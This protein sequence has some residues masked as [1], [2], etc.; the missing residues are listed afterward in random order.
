MS[1][2]VGL[3]TVTLL[4]VLLS[5]TGSAIVLL[6]DDTVTDWENGTFA[7]T[8]G[9]SGV[10]Q[11]SHSDTF[12]DG[13]DNNTL[14]TDWKR[15]DEPG[16][17]VWYTDQ[18]RNGE[19]IE[20]EM[21]EGA[22][23]GFRPDESGEGGNPDEIVPVF[24]WV[25][26]DWEEGSANNTLV[27]NITPVDMESDKAKTGIAIM[28]GS[29]DDGI[30]ASFSSASSDTFT[31]ACI[32]DDFESGTD[33]SG[34]TQI[35]HNDGEWLS[36]R[37]DY[38]PSTNEW[39]C[40]RKSQG[41]KTWTYDHHDS[42]TGTHNRSA[43]GHADWSSNG[44]GTTRSRHN[45]ISVTGV[46][47][48]SG[49]YT[50]QR[51]NN[52]DTQDWGKIFVNVTNLPASGDPDLV[53]RTRD[54]STGDILETE[55]FDLSS[56][57]QN[58]ST[59]ISD[60]IDAD[61]V[62]NGS[63]P[64]T[65]VSWSIDQV[66]IYHS[67]KTPPNITIYNPTNTTFSTNVLNLNVTADETTDDWQYS[68]DSN[69]N[70][71][72]S[73]NTT[74]SGLSMGQHHLIVYATDTGDN[75]GKAEVYFT[76]SDDDSWV[77]ATGDEM[78]GTL[79]MLG[80]KIINVGKMVMQ[81]IL[82]MGEHRI[83]NVSDPQ[84]PQDAATKSYVDTQEPHNRDNIH[85]SELNTASL[86]GRDTLIARTDTSPVNITIPYNETVD[87]NVIRIKD[88]DG[89]ACNNPITITAED[90][91][92]SVQIQGRDQI[93]LTSNYESV[94]LEWDDKLP[95]GWMIVNHHDPAGVC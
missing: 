44:D 22:S 73:P 37:I 85:V 49:N 95:G 34:N 13:K 82:D 28:E 14:S 17:S 63:S 54:N 67:D 48:K 33:G 77:N 18:G 41:S 86:E 43:F 66:T 20:I 60:S 16:S 53:F 3:L 61:F 92:G 12:N 79:D 8:S 15:V 94:E 71:T 81:G 26:T 50:S 84:E 19:A 40:A 32:D 7:N 46:H 10:L 30:T 90:G 36:V 23:D 4:L 35:T 58:Y 51:I 89:N 62:V 74:L 21:Q 52:T 64:N 6:N 59:S 1:R 56:G 72:F 57:G 83:I 24:D 5:A 93:K 39:W 42:D 27:A 78:R 75:T 47:P 70:E 87:G 2:T 31:F 65:S 25:S 80:N 69:A 29:T 55:Q 45:H 9:E 68:L 38:N 91:T 76:V 11:L 88:G